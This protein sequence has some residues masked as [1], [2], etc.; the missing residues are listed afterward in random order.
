MTEFIESF[1]TQQLLPP[2]IARGALT[3]GFAIRMN[4]CR[5]RDYLDRYFNGGY[6]DEAPFYYAPLDG[7]QFGLLGVAYFPNVASQNLQTASRL[8]PGETSWDH[9]SHNEAYLTFPVLRYALSKDNL[10]TDPV[11]VWV[12]PFVFS[13]NDSVV[14]SSREIWGSDM[15]L[16]SMVR[17]PGLAAHQLHFDM[18]MIGIKKFSPR[19]ISELLAVLHIR[20]RGDSEASLEDILKKNSDLDGF[21]KILGG[22]GAFA[23]TKP[24]GVSPSPYPSGVEL[25]NLKQFRDCYDMGAAIYRGIVASK[26]THTEVD[27]IVVFDPSKV[28]IAF[29]WSDSIAELLTEL[30]D[31][32][33]P[34][35]PG[36]PS[37][38]FE[39]A[40]RTR[41]LQAKY[42]NG[43]P[44]PPD[45]FRLPLPTTPNDMD[46]DMDRVVLKAEFGFSFSSNVHF[47]VLSTIHTYGLTSA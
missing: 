47:E 3:W 30:L 14:F 39:A 13:D 29:M 27:N 40:Q 28:E 11:L 9:L 6:P 18:G 23:G 1:A 35:D 17:Q 12:E 46:W 26:S 7:P 8:G 16:A 34:T 2:W 44:T 33:R 21:V 41:R 22:S 32:E 25:N 42:P 37:D 4:R 38:H 10:V 15:Y 20:T 5:I 19:S 43:V 31:V 36:P 45:T 24:K